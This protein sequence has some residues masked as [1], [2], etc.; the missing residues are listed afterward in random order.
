MASRFVENFLQFFFHLG[1]FLHWRTFVLWMMIVYLQRAR[2]TDDGVRWQAWLL[3]FLISIGRKRLFFSH[4][5]WLSRFLETWWS[6][7]TFPNRF[8]VFRGRSWLLFQYFSKSDS[9]V[10]WFV[11]GFRVCGLCFH[12]FRKIC[13]L[14]FHFYLVGF[15]VAFYFFKNFKSFNFF[16]DDLLYFVFVF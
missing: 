3:G 2:A 9:I 5:L 12:I 13:Y 15:K 6:F 8:G 11:W 1:L 14:L 4:L 16:I 10:A 7:T